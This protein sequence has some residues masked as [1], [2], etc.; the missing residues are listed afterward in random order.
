V[1]ASQSANEDNDAK[2]QH[3]Y[4]LVYGF[5]QMIEDEDQLG[6]VLSAAGHAWVHFHG[7][8]EPQF[9]EV[10]VNQEEAAP[11]TPAIMTAVK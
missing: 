10:S 11:D 4:N 1:A 3:I 2:C 5:C 6:A 7:N 8:Y 9:L